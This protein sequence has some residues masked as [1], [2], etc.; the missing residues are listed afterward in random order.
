M[1]LA[2]HVI[3]QKD[4]QVSYPLCLFVLRTI[5]FLLQLAILFPF[6]FMS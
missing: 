6:I 4:E 2:T 5:I 3:F 1:D